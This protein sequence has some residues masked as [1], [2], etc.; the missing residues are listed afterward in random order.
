MPK[1]I[2][3]IAKLKANWL[4]DPCWDI[5]DTEGFEEYRDQLTI[6]RLETERGWA[7]TQRKDTGNQELQNQ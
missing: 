3:D 2:N 6:F 1:D 4:K 7:K 5:E